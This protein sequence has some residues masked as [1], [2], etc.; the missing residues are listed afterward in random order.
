MAEWVFLDY[1]EATGH[2]PV[3]AWQ[4]ALPTEA[5][6]FIDARILQ[7]EGLAK[8]P[9]KWASKYEGVDDLFEMRI[10]F[11]KVQYRPLWIYGPWRR[12]CTI[13]VG[14]IE[15]GG[16]IPKADIVTAQ[17][18]MK[19]VRDDNRRIELHKFASETDLDEA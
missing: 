18:R 19:V 11:Q 2:N 10:T 12:H 6:A 8:W 15:K 7:M 13:L 16:K 3:L 17:Q 1:I 14:T 9:D 4:A 5:Q